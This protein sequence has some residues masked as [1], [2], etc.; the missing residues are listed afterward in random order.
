M[1]PILYVV[2]FVLLGISASIGHR[3]DSGYAVNRPMNPRPLQVVSG[4][5][6]IL[7]AVLFIVGFF[8]FAWWLP[9]IGVAAFATLGAAL[10]ITAARAIPAPFIGLSSGLAGGVLFLIVAFS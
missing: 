7:G 6:A 2:A 8:K 3:I 9:I 4:M 10:M 5:A 1:L